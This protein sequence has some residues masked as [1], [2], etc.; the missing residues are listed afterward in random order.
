MVTTNSTPTE[1]VEV[2]FV[3]PISDLWVYWSTTSNIT[4]ETSAEPDSDPG[5]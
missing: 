5:E 2:P 4:G 1:W 3:S